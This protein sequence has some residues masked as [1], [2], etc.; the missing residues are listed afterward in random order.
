MYTKM[1]IYLDQSPGYSLRKFLNILLKGKFMK[2]IL[3]VATL[4]AGTFAQAGII[5]TKRFMPN[6][7]W[8]GLTSEQEACKV[9]VNWLSDSEVKVTASARNSI[10]VILSDAKEIEITRDELNETDDEL[11]IKQSTVLV[12]EEDCQANLYET[13]VL[14]LENGHKLQGLGISTV[15]VD[16]ESDPHESDLTCYGLKKIK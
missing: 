7:T 9:E 13:V 8:T 14:D 1:F 16:Y 10:E 11:A 3:I 15:E 12:Q 2:T 5:Q 6:G 4:L